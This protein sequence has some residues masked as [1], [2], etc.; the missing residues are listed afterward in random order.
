MQGALHCYSATQPQGF[1]TAFCLQGCLS[2]SMGL[3]LG[4]AHAPPAPYRKGMHCRK[5]CILAALQHRHKRL[6]KAISGSYPCIIGPPDQG[7]ACHS[8]NME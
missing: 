1:H 5:S 6:P 4:T 2:K 8:P 7:E 3:L